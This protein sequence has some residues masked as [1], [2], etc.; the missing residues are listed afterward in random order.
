MTLANV[1]H[2]HTFLIF[3]GEYYGTHW[4]PLLSHVIVRYLSNS[5]GKRCFNARFGGVGF[6]FSTSIVCL[7]SDVVPGVADNCSES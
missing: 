2:Y 6:R 4:A 3:I 7:I 1:A 5:R